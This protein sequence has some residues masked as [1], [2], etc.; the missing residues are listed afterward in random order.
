M[1]I[2]VDSGSTKTDW[3]FCSGAEVVHTVK[4]QGI[5][6]IH[7]DN[8]T[9]LDILD[10]E[11]RP[12]LDGIDTDTIANVHFYGAGCATASVCDDMAA[13]LSSFFR[14]AHTEVASDMLGAARALC[15]DHEGIACVLG[16]GSNSCLYDGIRIVDQIP[17]LGYILGDEGSS[18]ALGKR[19]I[20]DCLKRQ[21]PPEVAQEFLT[22]YNL[23]IETVLEN[24]YRRPMANRYMADFTPFL[25][26]RRD[27]PQ[28]HHLLVSC[29]ADFFRRNVM[30]Y[31]KPWLPANF[32][33]SL[34]HSFSS[35][36]AEA[37]DSLGLS[38]GRVLKSPM[39]GLIEYHSNH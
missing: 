13:L 23:D 36:L 5:N 17:S 39:Q 21:L 25:Y 8:K 34:A 2:I 18:S 1:D 3:S 33:G 20:S 27:I 28:V 24:V 30:N 12:G 16:T 38:V 31:H 32:T 35:E 7:Q 6:P 37:A 4:T 29:F 9:I 26:E 10:N 15:M 14:K 19:L 22:T 11:L